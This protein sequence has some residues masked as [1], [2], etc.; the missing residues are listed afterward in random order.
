[1]LDPH[2]S[3]GVANHLFFLLA[4]GSGAHTV[5]GVAYNSPTCGGA[6]AVTGLG[7]DKAGKIWYR[8]LS[9]YMTSSETYAKA[10]ID[11]I[12]AANDLYGATEC[13]TVKAAWAAVSVGVQSGEAAC[14]GTGGEAPT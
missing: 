10:R 4:V 5:N 6:P 11:T 13:T 2:Y 14:A 8:A 12:K 7:N 3:S 9:T 1:G